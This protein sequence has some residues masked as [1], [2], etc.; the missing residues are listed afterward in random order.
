[1]KYA[2]IIA[3]GSVLASGVTAQAYTEFHF[4]PEGPF[5]RIIRFQ[6]YVTMKLFPSSLTASNQ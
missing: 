4:Y 3:G 6:E 5:P 2:H 1:M